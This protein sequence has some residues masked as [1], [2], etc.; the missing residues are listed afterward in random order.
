MKQSYLG[1]LLVFIFYLIS[2]RKVLLKTDWLLLLLFIVI[3]IDFHIISTI[4]IISEGMN[5]LNLQ[6]KGNVFLFSGFLSQLFSNVPATV[7]ISNFSHNWRAIAYGVNIGGNGLIIGS[8]ANI[9]AL[10]MAKN[11]KIWLDFH[12]YSIPYFLIT[13]GITYV[14]FFIL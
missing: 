11:K 13:G 6:S 10:R 5:I 12:R 7:L 9:I 3:F 4:P 1:L 14:L 8:L 2:Y